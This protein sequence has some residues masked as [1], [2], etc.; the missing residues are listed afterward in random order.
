MTQL[1]PK[2]LLNITLFELTRLFL[3]KRGLLAVAAFT[4]CWLLILRYPV[5]QAVSTMS[6]PEL[7][8]VAQHI[9]GVIGL[10]KLLMWPEAE[11]AM[12]WLIA[13]YSFPIFCLFL[14]SDQIVGDR[15][16]GTLRFLSLR[17]TRTEILFGRFLGQVLILAIL[18]TITLVATV[19]T[20]AFRESSLLLSG[21]NRSL[22]LFFYLVVTVLPFIA[23]MTFLNT[24]ARS[25]RLT[26]IMA[27]LFFAVGNIVVSLMS[28]QLPIFAILNYIFPGVQLEQVAG[29][30]ADLFSS[31]GIPL[32]QTVV[33]LVAAQRIFSRSSL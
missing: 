13:L 29:Q 21:L 31:I 28:W 16:R 27:I 1:N 15:Q 12:Y 19:A 4:I 17:A 24:I 30:N 5:G 23:L 33:L 25:S 26:V 7:A 20:L 14:C 3:T 10:S 9:F 11:L 6:S 2:R 8:A 18:I 32:L 22:V